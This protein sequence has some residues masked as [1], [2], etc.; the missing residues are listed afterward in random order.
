[1]ITYYKII[2][3]LNNVIGI[4]YI[5]KKNKLDFLFEQFEESD[6]IYYEEIDQLEYL[7]LGLE[8]EAFSIKG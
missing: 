6:Y 7:M 2:D 4:G 1:M 5:N 3:L 8:R